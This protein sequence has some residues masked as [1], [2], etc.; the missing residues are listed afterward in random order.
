MMLEIR[1]EKRDGHSLDDADAEEVLRAM[2]Q[3][4]NE[5]ISQALAKL[6]ICGVAHGRTL[7]HRNS[8]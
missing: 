8:A 1:I 7:P 5:Q 3:L 6:F 4:G 2:V